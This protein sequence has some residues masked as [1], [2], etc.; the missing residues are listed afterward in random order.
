MSEQGDIKAEFRAMN[1]IVRDFATL[2]PESRA[3]VLQRLSADSQQAG[4]SAGHPDTHGQDDED[5]V[6]EALT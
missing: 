1:R 5:A 3:W 2:T 6:R 4:T